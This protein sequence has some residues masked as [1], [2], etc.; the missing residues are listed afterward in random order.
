MRATLMYTIFEKSN[1]NMVVT[2]IIS[3]TL[4]NTPS[5]VEYRKCLREECKYSR[6]D[7]FPS[8]GVSTDKL[9]G[10]FTNLISAV[11]HNFPEVGVKDFPNPKCE[12]CNYSTCTNRTFGD[13]LF[14]EVGHCLFVKIFIKLKENN[15]K[16]YSF[17]HFSDVKVPFFLNIY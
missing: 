15:V 9:K 6:T 5:Y 14:I 7:V 12:Q 2:D 13:H 1:C 17:E 4:K 10:D 11:M 3:K 8:I 16:I